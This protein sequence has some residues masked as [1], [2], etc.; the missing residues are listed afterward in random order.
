[1]LFIDLK[2]ASDRLL[3]EIKKWALINREVAKTYKCDQ[4]YV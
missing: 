4:G 2:K 3:R 1:M